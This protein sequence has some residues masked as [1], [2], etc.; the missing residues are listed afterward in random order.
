VIEQTQCLIVGRLGLGLNVA[1]S[2]FLFLWQI[3]NDAAPPRYRLQTARHHGRLMSGS[4]H[5]RR[6]EYVPRTSA[7]PP[8]S[9]ALLSRRKRRSGP[10][11]DTFKNK[12]GPPCTSHPPRR[13]TLSKQTTN[14][15]E[16]TNHPGA[17]NKHSQAVLVF[18][19]SSEPAQPCRAPCWLS[20]QRH[21]RSYRHG[22]PI[23]SRTNASS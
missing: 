16:Q 9:D 11:A 3:D 13:A 1:G 20:P 8:I 5:Q 10:E 14:R 7:L 18:G 12:R 22:Y 19:R 15:G 6:F 2:V 17:S 21:Q 4:G 23:V